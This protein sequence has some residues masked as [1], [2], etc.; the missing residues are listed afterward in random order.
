[1]FMDEINQLRRMGFR[2]VSLTCIDVAFASLS[3]QS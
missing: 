3:M 2:A 1:M